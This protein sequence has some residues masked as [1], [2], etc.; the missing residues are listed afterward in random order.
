MFFHHHPATA[1]ATS[2]AAPSNT[3]FGCGEKPCAPTYAGNRERGWLPEKQ[4]ATAT[5]NDGPRANSSKCEQM[6][7]NV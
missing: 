7:E 4:G 5:T 1:V 6:N 2:H 3:P